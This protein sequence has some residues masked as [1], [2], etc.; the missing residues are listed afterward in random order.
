MHTASDERPITDC[1]PTAGRQGTI[2]PRPPLANPVLKRLRGGFYL[3]A[4]AV[5]GGLWLLLDPGLLS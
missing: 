1:L 5:C 2:G 3:P 4:L